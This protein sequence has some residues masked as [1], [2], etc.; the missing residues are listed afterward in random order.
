MLRE[1]LR[2]EVLRAWGRYPLKR[3]AAQDAHGGKLAERPREPSVELDDGV[4]RQSFAA[5]WLRRA[6]LAVQ[7]K[8]LVGSYRVDL[9][10]SQTWVQMAARIASETIYVC[11]GALAFELLEIELEHALQ[12]ERLT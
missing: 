9:P 4:G 3:V 8:D 2:L 5:R 7:L 12:S 10:L 11:R 6:H 1:R